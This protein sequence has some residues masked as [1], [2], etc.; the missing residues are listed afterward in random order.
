VK[1]VVKVVDQLGDEIAPG[2]LTPFTIID[3][4]T[5]AVQ[6]VP[7]QYGA[8]DEMHLICVYKH[9][10]DVSNLIVKRQSD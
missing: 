8:E 6:F 3:V 4:E 1:T 5:R 2:L 7:G 9:W 10:E